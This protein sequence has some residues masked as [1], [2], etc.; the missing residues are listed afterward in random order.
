MCGI[1]GIVSAQAFDPRR[2]VSMTQKVQ[3][4]GGMWAFAIWD[5]RRKVLFCSRDRFGEKPVYYFF[6]DQLFFF[7]SEIKQILQVATVSREADDDVVLAFLGDG[8]LDHTSKTF[9]RG[10]RQL[11]KPRLSNTPA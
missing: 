4:R 7:P 8:L 2:L 9:F 1:A 5:C 6:D 3:H 11:S 10:G